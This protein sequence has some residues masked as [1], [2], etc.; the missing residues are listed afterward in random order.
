MIDAMLMLAIMAADPRTCNGPQCA[1][2]RATVSHVATAC[3]CTPCRCA[4]SCQC[5]DGA[6]EAVERSRCFRR[7]PQWAWS[8][9]ARRTKAMCRW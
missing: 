3:D 6:K 4:P 9:K 8:I 1:V 7:K 5:G 2:V